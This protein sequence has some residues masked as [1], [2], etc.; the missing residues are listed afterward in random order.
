MS[1][2]LVKADQ[3]RQEFDASFASAHTTDERGHERLLAIRVG[4]DPHAIRLAQISALH[5]D[6]KVVPIPSSAHGLLGIAG[7]RIGMV[8][9][10]DLRVLLGYRPSAP[11]RWMVL[12]RAGET[13]GLAFDR[14]EAHLRVTR[15]Q[16][17]SLDER[18]HAQFIV[19][20]VHDGSVVR[21]VID[22][23]AVARAIAGDG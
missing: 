21:S 14:M 10:Y 13:I 19:G 15:E 22:L 12:V 8:A 9:V 7:M 3:L 4:D 11:A 20:A 1:D 16:M 6:R 2:T 23:E 18:R 17:Q 5:A